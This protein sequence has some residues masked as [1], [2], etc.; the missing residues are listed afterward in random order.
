VVGID[1]F[2]EAD[3]RVG[4]LTDIHVL[5][6]ED[7]RDARDILCMV[8]RYFGA[9][10]TAVPTAGEAL[11][12]LQNVMPDVV[13]ADMQLPDHDAGWLTREA[14]SQGVMVPFISVSALDFDAELVGDFGFDAYL[15]KPVDHIRLVD[16][17]LSVVRRDR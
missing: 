16:A 12:H 2:G 4:A 3:S 13:L 17:I 11:R 5:V 6:V 8:L 10:V 9:M 14:R 1:P 7:D 15:R